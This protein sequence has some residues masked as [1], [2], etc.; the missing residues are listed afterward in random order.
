MGC[1]PRLDNGLRRANRG[2]WWMHGQ[3]LPER[4]RGHCVASP[5]RTDIH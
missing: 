2:L 1:A 5:Q 3:P 4:P